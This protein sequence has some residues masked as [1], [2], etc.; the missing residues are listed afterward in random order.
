MSF[1]DSSPVFIPLSNPKIKYGNTFKVSNIYLTSS[2]ESQ[3]FKEVPNSSD[4]TSVFKQ[5]FSDQFL[6]FSWNLTDPKNGYIYS[7]ENEIK[8]NPYIS[9]FDVSIYKNSGE[10]DGLNVVT[11]RSKIFEKKNLKG[12]SFSY[13]ITGDKTHRNYSIDVKFTDF[14]GNQS[15]GILTSI[16]PVPEFSILSTGLV[17]GGFQL[18]YSG[19]TNSNGISTSNGLVAV[20]LYNF[21]GLTSGSSG[22]FSQDS[23]YFN[24]YERVGLGVNDYSQVELSPGCNNYVLMLARDGYNTGSIS[25]FFAPQVYVTGIGFSGLSGNLKA[26]LLVDYPINVNPTTGYRISGAEAI[27]YS[28]SGDYNT[29]SSLMYTCY[30]ITGTG[31]TTGAVSGYDDPIFLDS[32]ILYDTSYNHNNTGY[33]YVY[34]NSLSL[35]SGLYTGVRINKQIYTGSGIT[36]SGTIGS[37]AGEFWK[38]E[39]PKYTGSISGTSGGN[40]DYCYFDSSDNK[41]GCASELEIKSGINYISGIYSI[42]R[43]NPNSYKIRYRQGSNFSKSYEQASSY[44]NALGEM[45]A[46]II[47]N[48]QWEKIKS[49]NAGLGWIGLRRN[50]VSILSGLFLEDSKNQDFFL[51]TTFENAQQSGFK[52][53]NSTGGVESN[54]LFVNNVGDNWAWVNG[55]GTQIYKYAG[56][57]YEKVRTSEISIDVKRKSDDYLITGA[58]IRGDAPR[59]ELKNVTTTQESNTVT[60][61]YDFVNEY[62]NDTI[63]S[64]EGEKPDLNYNNYNATELR[65][66]TGIGSTFPLNNENLYTGESYKDGSTTY[67]DTFVFD[68]DIKKPQP[69]YFKIIPYDSISSGVIFETGISIIPTIASQS[70]VVDLDPAFYASENFVNVTFPYLHPSE[71]TVSATL[72]YTGTVGTIQYLGSMLS[73]NPTVSGATFILTAAPSATGYV[74]EVS[75]ST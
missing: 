2:S 44:L 34:D 74:L 42:P 51:N 14:T 1:S 63:P 55:S 25:G 40:Y 52:T 64:G 48:S 10:L 57:G 59:P 66:Y 5:D 60:F 61:S 26:P 22:F 28:F 12:N 72:S 27:Y 11:G 62:Y 67:Q 7:V 43:N 17:T 29:G 70:V 31:I 58:K 20:D 73:G 45:P 15:S 49:L 39:C 18:S 19:N 65:V 21:T 30:G 9:G 36:G 13:E 54:E 16:N 6:S 35:Q 71:P 46:V 3:F 50:K 24:T 23:G 53:I 56:S 33:L 69:D 47:N 4:N 37:G 75:T 32:G 38:S 68:S 8:N 41:I